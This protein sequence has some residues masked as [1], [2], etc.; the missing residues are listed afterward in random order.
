MTPGAEVSVVDSSHGL[1]RGSLTWMKCAALGIS[2]AVAGCFAGW[3]YGLAAGG[4][5]G[6]LVAA[7]ATGVLFFS[8]TQATA[9]LAAAMPEQA[10]FDAYV[11]AM[12][13][14]LAGYLAGICVA[15]GLAIGTGL[16][17]TFTA[18][19]TQG[20][21]GIGGWTVKL[22]LLAIVSLLHLRGAKEAVGF[23]MLVGGIAVAVLALFCATSAPHFSSSNLFAAS[24]AGPTLFPHGVWGVIEAVPFGLFMFLGVEQSA[25]GAAEVSDP[26]RAMPRALVTAVLF[27]VLMG[28]LVLI[29]ATGASG[30]ER[31]AQAD[32]PLLAAVQAQGPGLWRNLL[33]Y[34]V[35][36]GALISFLAA[37]FSLAYAASRQLHHLASSGGL[38]AW[39]ATTNRR[40]A[41]AAAIAV[42]AVICTA[43]AAFPPSAVMVVFMFLLVLTYELVLIAFLQFQRAPGNV[44]RPFRAPGGRALGWLG[45][46]LAFLVALCC[47]QLQ[48]A[49]LSYALILL[50]LMLVYFVWRRRGDRSRSH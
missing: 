2:I 30:V 13:G 42:V 16:A 47:Y 12:L 37:L 40:G 6:M 46:V 8:L 26:A 20:M 49:A 7:V 33:A 10:G 34:V 11:R 32:A 1:T 48:I 15:F 45:V 21:M 3:N 31:L 25:Q 4:W 17:L 28:I 35:G 24:T 18:A 23:T 41:P 19:Y 5:G 50:A 44:Q 14:P 39:L 27:S 22:I 43:A 9:E 29:L 38:P 36:I